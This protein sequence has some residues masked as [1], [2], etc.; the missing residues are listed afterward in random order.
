MPPRYACF[1]WNTCMTTR[2]CRPS[3]RSVA[4]AWLKYASL[5]QPARIFSTG[6]SKTAGSRRLR[7]VIIFEA[8]ACRQRSLGH[9]DLLARRVVGA[10][11][12]L[13][14]VAGPGERACQRVGRV[15]RHPGEDLRRR[16]HGADRAGRTRRRPVA[17]GC[18]LAEQARRR[19]GDEHRPDEVR[20][21]ALVLLRTRLPVLVR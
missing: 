1:F 9:L 5:Y 13:Q 10:D 2:G 21:A 3:A 14:L 19:R 8:Q 6:R 7:V 4:R 18:A 11:A 15:A 17:L 16:R 20:A 12:V